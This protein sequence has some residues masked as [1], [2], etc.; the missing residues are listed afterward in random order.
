MTSAAIEDGARTYVPSESEQTEAES[1]VRMFA[2]FS[3]AQPQS[4]P[5]LVATDGTRHELP[6]AIFEA[7]QQVAQ[8]LSHGH[9][10]TVAS[11]NARLTTQQAADFLGISRPTF[12][13][14]LERGELSMEK[15]GR[16][17]FVRLDDLLDYESRTRTNRREALENMVTEAEDL[18]LYDT[19]DRRVTT[20]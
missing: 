20:R 18:G 10:V 16:H 6:Q 13:R 3:D 14:I 19:T 8:A 2:E 11:R 4:R 7:L 1:F 15:P 5:A 9:G 17:R 12:V